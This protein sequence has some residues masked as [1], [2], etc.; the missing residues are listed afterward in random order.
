[1]T[2]MNKEVELF[3]A[4]AVEELESRL[5]NGYYGYGDEYYGCCIYGIKL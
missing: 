2:E 3:R 5:Q 4:F 1:M